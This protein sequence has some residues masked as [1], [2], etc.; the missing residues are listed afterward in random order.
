[1]ARGTGR[2]ALLAAALAGCGRVDLPVVGFSPGPAAGLENRVWQEEGDPQVLRAFLSDGTMLTARCG[3][4]WRLSAWRR[5]DDAT[6]A[7]ETAQGSVQAE[8][9]VQG[10]RELALVIDPA[11]TASTLA[12]RAA[13]APL[14]CAAP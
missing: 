8:I 14:D 2:M 11:G 1:M 13:Q 7:W 10:P 3:E 9:A 4:N 12:F 6:L 5:V